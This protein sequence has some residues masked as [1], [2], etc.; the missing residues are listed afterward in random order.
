MG[1]AKR[2]LKRKPKGKSCGG[3]LFGRLRPKK[4]GQGK[5][6]DGSKGIKGLWLGDERGE[7]FLDLLI[8]FMVLVSVI[9]SFLTLPELFVKKQQIDYMART[10]ARRVEI[11]GELNG[12]VYDTVNSLAYEC[13]F[14]PTIEWE[15]NFYGTGN[16]LQIRERFK[17]TLGHTVRITLIDPTFTN[18]VYLDIPMGKSVIGVSEVYWKE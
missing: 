12:R 2:K 11:E 3:E 18:P 8:G 15:G 13:G 16:K 14:M 4:C 17:V 7:Y 5:A 6:A 9:L 1:M 10:I